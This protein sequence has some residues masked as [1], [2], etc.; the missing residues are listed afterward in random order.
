MAIKWNT[1]KRLRVRQVAPVAP[2]A[3]PTPPVEILAM[4]WAAHDA[5]EKAAW[6][7]LDLDDGEDP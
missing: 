4:A 1:T 6:D 7:A 2:P 3:S 5:A